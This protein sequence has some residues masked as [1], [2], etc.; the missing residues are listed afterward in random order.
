LLLI[1]LTTAEHRSGA[2]AFYRK[3]GFEETDWRF[4]KPLP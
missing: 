4:V 3:L 1:F 2:H